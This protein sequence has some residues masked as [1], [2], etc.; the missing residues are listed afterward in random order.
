MS[1]E[2][3]TGSF[4][5]EVGSSDLAAVLNEVVSMGR[6]RVIER[7]A[8]IHRLVE[9]GLFCAAKAWMDTPSIHASDPQLTDALRRWANEVLERNASAYR[10]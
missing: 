2:K 7:N 1:T 8:T 5:I 3:N 9:E 6:D 10:F 4:S